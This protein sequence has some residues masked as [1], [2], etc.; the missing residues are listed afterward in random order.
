MLHFT[1]SRTFLPLALIA[2][3]AVTLV[4][5]VAFAATPMEPNGRKTLVS[6]KGLDLT[7]PRDVAILDA[8]LKSAARS[9]CSTTDMRSLSALAQRTACE[10]KAMAVAGKR[11]DTLIADAQGQSVRTA[12]VAP[13]AP[14]TN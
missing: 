12:A 10:E 1:P 2:A 5:G 4:Q 3:V 13:Q 11:R 14:T 6:V 9:V 8:R 7:S